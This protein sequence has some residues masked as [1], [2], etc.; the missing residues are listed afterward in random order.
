MPITLVILCTV[1]VWAFVAWC[2]YFKYAFVYFSD[3]P[4][5]VKPLEV[6]FLFLMGVSA[7]FLFVPFYM[8]ELLMIGGIFSM[9]TILAFIFAREDFRFPEDSLFSHLYFYP[10]EW[11]A[12]IGSAWVFYGMMMFPVITLSELSKEMARFFNNDLSILH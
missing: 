1:C 12:S 8:P 5:K 7:L 4:D 10:M 2:N 11:K 6:P 9:V 3:Y